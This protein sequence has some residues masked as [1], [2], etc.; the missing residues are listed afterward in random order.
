MPRHV[1]PEERRKAVVH[2]AIAI[3]KRDDIAAVT[4]RSVAGEKG[5]STTAVTHYV[6]TRGDLFRLIFEHLSCDWRKDFEARLDQRDPEQALR[7]LID[8]HLVLDDLGF[9]R[10]AVWFGALVEAEIRAGLADWVRDYC[11]WCEGCMEDLLGRFYLP[12]PPALAR[13]MT[14]SLVDG[15]T[16]QALLAPSEWPARRQLAAV[17]QLLGML[18]VPPRG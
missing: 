8:E 15:I 12:V 14:M 7:I 6:E 13:D 16:A 2:A 4:F 3:A 10:A 9:L 17:E 5:M 1:D 11:H 18:G